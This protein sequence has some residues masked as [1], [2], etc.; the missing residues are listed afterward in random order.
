M[1]TQNLLILFILIANCAIAQYYTEVEDVDKLKKYETYLM[2][3]PP[4]QY[5]KI[6][7]VGVAPVSKSIKMISYSSEDGKHQALVNAAREDLFL[8]A[9]YSIIAEN[10]VPQVVLD[11]IETEYTNREPVNYFAV[12]EPS[13]SNYFAV[14][15]MK[16]KEIK[17]AHFD[18]LGRKKQ[19]PY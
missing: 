10:E 14:D 12:A 4:Q 19:N 9:N 16:D 8:I 5:E 18:E 2:N 6:E 15:L 11:K 17:R 13:A 7:V 1:K 3:K